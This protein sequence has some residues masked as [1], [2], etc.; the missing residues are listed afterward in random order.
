M[1]LCCGC[2][3]RCRVLVFG[4]V[5][6]AFGAL[7][8]CR[9]TDGL[10][11][12]NH[13]PPRANPATS[14][15]R[16]FPLEIAP[17]PISLGSV[18]SGQRAKAEF[19]LVNRGSGAI[20]VGSIATSCPCL[21]VR[22]RSVRLEPGE[23]RVLTAEFDGSEEPDFQGGLA[24]SVTGYAGGAEAFHTVVE[25]EVRQA[26]ARALAGATARPGEGGNP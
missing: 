16:G 23:A 9:A 25:V 24:I 11:S 22:P 8:A 3:G 15:A 21:R 4:V 19:T 7:I 20:Q 14:P 17:D 18:T 1:G 26:D 6:V 2:D 10:T 5:P 12:A 13:T